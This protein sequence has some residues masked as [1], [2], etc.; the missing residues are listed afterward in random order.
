MLRDRPDALIVMPDHLLFT[1]R[2]G[3]IDF[4][5]KNDLPAMY[6]LREYVAGGGLM[7][8]WPDCVAMF[9]RAASYVDKIL[10]GA[11]PAELP[12]EQPIKFELVLNLKTAKALGLT[13]PAHLLML[14]DEVF[15]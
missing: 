15:Q 9:R 14:A 11:K 2:E 12:V 4:A 5:A 13:F 8:Y 10:Q 3:I 1:Q 7:G 6:L